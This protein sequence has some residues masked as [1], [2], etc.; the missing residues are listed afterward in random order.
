MDNNTSRKRREDMEKEKRR[1][2][3]PRKQPVENTA[4]ETSAPKKRK[5]RVNKIAEMAKGLANNVVTANEKTTTEATPPVKRRRGRPR[6]NPVA[7]EPTP[8]IEAA[9]P[10]DAVAE[11]TQ[12]VKKRRGRP[13]KNPVAIET[14][15]KVEAANLQQPAKRRRGRPRKNPLNVELKKPAVIAPIKETKPHTPVS[16]DKKEAAA[17]KSVEQ[18]TITVLVEAINNLTRE[19]KILRRHLNK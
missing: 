2:G 17:T 19:V 13:R 1:R 15:P 6:K 11:T 10:K 7:V 12:P 16:V 14:T 4:S 18:N 5:K 8:K 3:R 9:Q